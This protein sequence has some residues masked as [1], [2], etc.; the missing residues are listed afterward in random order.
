MALDVSAYKTVH[1]VTPAVDL[2][3]LIEN[4]MGDHHAVVF[5]PGTY[6]YT[7][8]YIN[9][10]WH[11]THLFAEEDS[12]MAA[13]LDPKPASQ[14]RIRA[15]FRFFGAQE[16]RATGID[17]LTAPNVANF[18]TFQGTYF[19][20][21][22]Y[23]THINGSASPW[24]GGGGFISSYGGGF[25]FDSVLRNCDINHSTEMSSGTPI[26]M[27]DGG[28]LR[29]TAS[30]NGWKPIVRFGKSVGIQMAGVGG[31][32][33]D[34]DIFGPGKS[35]NS[36]G[37][38]VHRGGGDA[39]ILKSIGSPQIA[40]CGVAIQAVSGGVVKVRAQTNK[41]PLHIRNCRIGLATPEGGKIHVTG[42]K[43]IS[44]VG[45]D[46]KVAQDRDEVI[47]Q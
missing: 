32:M 8:G 9:Y 37:L 24:P 5:A 22:V 46:V 41:V 44:F 17:F 18:Y 19:L 40:N 30:T 26:K 38:Y 16:M 13:P 45:V 43:T 42:D 33:H 25:S 1:E 20:S 21:D 29:M 2:K 3:D 36:I 11:N 28:Y 7:D 10:P 31:Y 12:Y 47:Y 27:K 15:G 39:F 14:V 23:G 6:S 34:I 35:T 4:Q